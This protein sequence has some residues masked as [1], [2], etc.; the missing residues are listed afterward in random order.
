MPRKI[1]SKKFFAARVYRSSSPASHVVSLVLSLPPVESMGRN[2]TRLGRVIRPIRYYAY[3]L[4]S[5]T[6]TPNM[7]VEGFALSYDR[8]HDLA[9]SRHREDRRRWHGGSVSCPRRATRS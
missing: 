9:L 3:P 2:S 4:T 8:S 7:T 5:G 6:Q 1:Y